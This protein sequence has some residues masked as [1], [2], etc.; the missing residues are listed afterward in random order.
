MKYC[1]GDT[2]EYN[3]EE[4]GTILHKTTRNMNILQAILATKHKSIIEQYA[5]METTYAPPS[6]YSGGFSKAM[7]CIEMI[8]LQAINNGFG[9][10]GSQDYK[11]SHR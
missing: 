7:E 8:A 4:I 9:T 11:C 10:V 2:E 3:E 5:N 1:E 6:Q